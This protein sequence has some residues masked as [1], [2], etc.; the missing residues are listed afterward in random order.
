MNRFTFVVQV[1]PGGI[2]TLENVKTQERVRIEDLAVI[3]PQIEEWLERLM[4]E[5]DQHEVAPS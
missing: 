2:S 4:Q 1:H 3:G 5:E